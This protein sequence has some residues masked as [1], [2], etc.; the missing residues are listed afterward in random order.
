MNL[1]TVSKNAPI[2]QVQ[3]P[4]GIAVKLDDV[5]VEYRLRHNRP[6]SL[7]EYFVRWI[8]RDLHLDSLLALED[9]SL[10]IKSGEVFAIIGRNGAGKSTLLKV[11][12]GILRPT[13]GRVRTFGQTVSLLGVGAG[14]HHELTGH[15]NIYLYS[16]VLG[17]TKAW[18][19]EI[20]D[21]VVEF[22]ELSDFINAPLRTYSTGMIARLGF[23][24]AMAEKPDILLVDEVL[25]VGDEQFQEKCRARFEEF[26]QSG[27]TVIIA[28]H[29]LSSVRSMSQ[30]AVWLSNGH[31]SMLGEATHVAQSYHDF[32][33]QEDHRDTI[34][35]GT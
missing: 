18:T 14:F 30:R 26:K 16:A 15:E 2:D 4:D 27:T 25:G 8:Q 22:A 3:L 35:N 5:M 28:T 21:R 24:V 17:R 34:R 9:I 31:V 20:F 7:K 6:T 10:E 23:A 29:S 1:F 32:L 12:A 13:D 19:D 11:I 33:K